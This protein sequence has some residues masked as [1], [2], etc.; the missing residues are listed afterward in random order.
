M[1]HCVAV[2]CQFMRSDVAGSE[3]REALLYIAFE[4]LGRRGG[5]TNAVVLPEVQR[6]WIQEVGTT[7]DP[8]KCWAPILCHVLAAGT[9]QAPEKLLRRAARVSCVLARLPW[10]QGLPHALVSRRVTDD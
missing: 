6:E 4:V 2:K 7:T 3:K 10:V 1:T 9:W 5:C 8:V